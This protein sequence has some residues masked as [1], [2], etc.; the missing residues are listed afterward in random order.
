MTP[1]PTPAPIAPPASNPV[2]A[3][4]LTVGAI[5]TGVLAIGAAIFGFVAAGQNGLVSALVGVLF[6]ALFL[7]I[8]AG[9]ILFANRWNGDPLY[10]TLFFAIVLGGWLVK[11]VLFLVAFFLIRDQPWL[12]TM[13]FFIALVVSVMAMLIVDVFVMAKMRIPYVSD[14]ELPTMP[15]EGSDEVAPSSDESDESPESSKNKLDLDS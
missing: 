8:T 5:V 3:K 12:V 6:G 4:V 2:L 7:G 9:S 13:P 11:F 15:T 14:A 1:E 10:P